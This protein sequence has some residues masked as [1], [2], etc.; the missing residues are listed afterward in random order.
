MTASGSAEAITKSSKSNLA[1][2]FVSLPKERRNDMTTFYAFCRIVDDIADSHTLPTVEKQTQL[3]AWRATIDA[4]GGSTEPALADDVRSLIAKYKIPREHFHEIINGVEMDLSPR[5]YATFGDLRLYCYRVASAVGLASIEIFGYKNPGC[6]NY[7]IDL[8]LA[9]Q[10]TNIIRD[11]GEDWANGGRIYLPVEDMERFGFSEDD[12]RQ[13]KQNAAFDQ[14]IRFEAQRA[15]EFYARATAELPPE[16]ARSMVAAEIMHRVYGTLLDKMER[17][18][19]RVLEKRYAHGKWKKTGIV[20]R[21]L[22][23]NI[24]NRRSATSVV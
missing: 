5:R 16:D 9:L 19:F 14:L 17:G 23:V 3:N 13:R 11:V 20:A 10:L 2:A 18:G 15:R 22:L 4:P 6:K 12:L 21:V 1:L 24:M 7:A 8:G